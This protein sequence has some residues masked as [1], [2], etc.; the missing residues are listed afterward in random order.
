MGKERDLFAPSA[1]VEGAVGS[2]S[3]LMAGR[4]QRWK[5]KKEKGVNRLKDSID[6]YLANPTDDTRNSALRRYSIFM[7]PEAAKALPAGQSDEALRGLAAVLATRE[8]RR[9][10]AFKEGFMSPEFFVGSSPG[11]KVKS[12]ISDAGTKGDVDLT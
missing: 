9:A 5:A 7:G 11:S 4:L 3:G 12:L 8:G 10:L 2:A 6:R 1:R